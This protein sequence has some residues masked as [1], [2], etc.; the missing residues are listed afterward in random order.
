MLR[1]GVEVENVTWYLKNSMKPLKASFIEVL[2][3]YKRRLSQFSMIT[4]T[5]REVSVEVIREGAL[6][7]ELGLAF[8]YAH[9]GGLFQ[10]KQ[11]TKNPQ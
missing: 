3:I 1:N 4:D 10:T 2:E 11:Y 9:K 8:A 5:C 7:E 6:E